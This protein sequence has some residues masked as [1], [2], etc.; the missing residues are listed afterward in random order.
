[1]A[2]LSMLAAGGNAVAFRCDLAREED[3]TALW[4]YAVSEFSHV[5]VLINNAAILVPGTIEKM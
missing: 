3:M 2:G 5:D 4:E 1:M